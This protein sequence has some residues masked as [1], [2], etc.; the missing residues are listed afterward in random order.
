MKRRVFLLASLLLAGVAQA[1][2]T[3]AEGTDYQVVKPAQPTSVAPGQIEVIEFFS[4]ACPHCFAFEPQVEAWAAKLPAN[5]VF[6]RVPA[7]MNPHWNLLAR[8]YYTA[9]AL[10]VLSEMHQKIFQEI[11]VKRNFLQTEDAVRELFVSSAGVTA[12]QFDNA[13]NSFTVNMKMQRAEV[14][15]KRY[16]LRAVPSMAVQGKYLITAGRTGF[17]GMLEMVNN[18]VQQESGTAPE[19]TSAAA[20]VQ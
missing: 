8:A 16:K 19:A 20:S 11:H 6:K 9:E 1:A 4:Y 17:G 15:T 12:E 10:D 7:P 3:F 2:G 13:F 14:L 18:F 5:V